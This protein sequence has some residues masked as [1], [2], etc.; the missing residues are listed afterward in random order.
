MTADNLHLFPPFLKLGFS[1]L[2]LSAAIVKM[3]RL[4][5]FPCLI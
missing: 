1:L 2:N 4:R 3:A 5:N